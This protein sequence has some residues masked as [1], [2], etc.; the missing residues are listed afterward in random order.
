MQVVFYTIETVGS[1]FLGLGFVKSRCLFCW[2]SF[3]YEHGRL[4]QNLLLSSPGNK[5]EQGDTHTYTHTSFSVKP[6]DTPNIV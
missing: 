3:W 6:E 1:K 5:T 4:A 2:Q